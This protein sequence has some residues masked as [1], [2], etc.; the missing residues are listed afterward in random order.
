MGFLGSVA[1]VLAAGYL[2]ALGITGWGWFLLVAVL[3][4][5]TIRDNPTDDESK[6]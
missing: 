1:A 6:K 2:A 3:L 5:G 4:A